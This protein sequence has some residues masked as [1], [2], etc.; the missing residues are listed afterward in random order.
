LNLIDS[1]NMTKRQILQAKMFKKKISQLS[2]QF[3]QHFKTGKRIGILLWIMFI[4]FFVFAIGNEAKRLEYLFCDWLERHAC[5]FRQANSDIVIIS[6]DSETLKAVP[7][8]WPWPRDKYAQLQNKLSEAKPRFIIW[9]IL[10]Q[11]PQSD[12]LGTGD[13]DFAKAISAAGNV[14][15]VSF[16]ENKIFPSGIQKVHSQN[17][18]LLREAATFQGIVRANIDHDGVS[19][20]FVIQD[21]DMGAK[22]IALWIAEQMGAPSPVLLPDSTNT[23]NFLL[24]HASKNGE[25]QQV[26]AHDIFRGSYAENQFRDKILVIGNTAP[27]LHDYHN[28]ARGLMSG[29]R[30]L[31]VSIDTLLSGRGAELL[32]GQSWQAV[33]VISAMLI[34]ILAYIIWFNQPTLILICLTFF[35]TSVWLMIKELLKFCLPL[36]SFLLVSWF[37]LI[38]LTTIKKFMDAIEQQQLEAEAAA[39]GKVQQ[40]LFPSTPLE[41]ETHR[42]DGICIPCTSAGGDF[43]EM[44]SHPSGKSFFA[45]ADVMGHGIPAALVTS[46]IK[47]VMTIHRQK[48]IFSL[49][50]CA[51]EINN[52][53]SSEFGRRKMVSAIFGLFDPVENTCELAVAGHPAAC[54]F[55]QDKKINEIT[56]VSSPLGLFKKPKIAMTKLSMQTGETLVLYTDG[57]I[58][59]LNWNNEPFGYDRWKHTIANLLSP[60][61]GNVN[62]ER[63]F[64]DMRRHTEGRIVDDDLTI[65]ILQTKCRLPV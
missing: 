23:D 3:K 17:F 15:L 54:Y 30:L 64:D 62:I 18:Q 5:H 2:L 12:Y 65:V 1:K 55:Q 7:D 9:D 28:T 48:D 63:F 58:E 16:I 52:V 20:S 56:S 13:I 35:S 36:G 21:R 29:P 38:S 6:I 19:R 37:L 47:T 51:A 27:I 42:I 33:A 10:F 45:I 31:A 60:D 26:S 50:D 24:A 40:Q 41:L 14:V 44:F 59:A 11:H 25:I 57:I 46:M 8:R 49:Y 43:F 4:P 61:S 32:H 34:S 22:S 39:A 53:I